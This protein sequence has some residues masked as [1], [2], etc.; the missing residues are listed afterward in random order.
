MGIEEQIK[1]YIETQP[2]VKR[3]DMNELHKVILSIM[4]DCRLWYI[5][6]K[7][8]KGKIVSNP[9]IGYGLRTTKYAD[10]KS[11]DY[12]RIGISANK[13]GISVYI[14]GIED[15]NFLAQTYGGKIGK[16]GV[17]GYCIKFKSLKD[18]DVK[19]LE[20]AIRLGIGG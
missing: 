7:D 14:F 15:K 9:S 17:S 18:I 4:P 3:N 6:G 10:G 5:D 20:E 13:S 1:E 16:A 11:K 12:Y 8:E 19:V 2:E